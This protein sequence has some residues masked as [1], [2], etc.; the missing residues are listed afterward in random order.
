MGRAQELVAQV[1]ARPPRPEPEPD[2]LR[3]GVRR[4]Q[5]DGSITVVDDWD[6]PE[7]STAPVVDRSPERVFD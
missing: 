1:Q 3:S 6:Q 5:A 7:Q 2:A 4:T